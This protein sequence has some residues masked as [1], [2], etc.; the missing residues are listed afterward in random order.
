[1]W[2][3]LASGFAGAC[4]VTV[5]NE[6]IRQF[7]DKAPRLDVLGERSVSKFMSDDHLRA[8]ALA[9]DLTTDSLFFA[10]VGASTPEQ[11][12]ICGAALGLAAGAGALILPGPMGLGE[13]ATNRTATTKALSVA[14]YATG[15]LLA[16]MLYRSLAEHG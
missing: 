8:K 2:K 16:G 1:M 5:L 9:G 10:I 14:Y 3:A 13:D 6:S 15:G 12:P 11:A 4:A 7:W